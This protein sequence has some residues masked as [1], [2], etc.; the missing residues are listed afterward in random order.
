MPQSTVQPKV[1]PI[2]N[3]SLVE[4]KDWFSKRNK[5]LFLCQ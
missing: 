5:Y 1:G 4:I 2:Y 3:G